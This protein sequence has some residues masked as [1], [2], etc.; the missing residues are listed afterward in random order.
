MIFIFFIF[1][2]ILKIPIW[3]LFLFFKRI[4]KNAVINSSFNILKFENVKTSIHENI[5][6]E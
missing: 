4:S 2:K 5:P 1:L 6:R 3:L